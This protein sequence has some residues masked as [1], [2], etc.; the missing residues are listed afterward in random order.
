MLDLIEKIGPESYYMAEPE[1]VALCRQ[2]IWTP[3]LLDRN[4]FVIW[5]QKGS[6]SLEDRVNDKLRKILSTHQSPPLPD[7]A[8][9]AIQ[10]LLVQAEGRYL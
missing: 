3:G 6:K 10:A 8:A 9:E 5:E 4:P 7:G 2:E 1:S